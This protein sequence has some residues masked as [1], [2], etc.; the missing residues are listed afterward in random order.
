M[1]TFSVSSLYQWPRH[2]TPKAR[3]IVLNII[4]SSKTPL[5]TKDIYNLAIKPAR[6]NTPAPHAGEEIRSMRYLKTVVLRNLAAQNC[7]EKVRTQGAFT[8]WLWRPKQA[9]PASPTKR[10]VMT[11]TLP[12][13]TELTPAA[14]GVGEDWSHLNNRRQRAR[15]MK[16]ERDLQRM[17]EVQKM[18]RKAVL[19][20]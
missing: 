15:K 6:A 4:N 7:V 13:S 11:S 5:A 16:V 17:L 2:C 20:H 10:K 3:E 12:G 14:V 9:P 1:T 19:Q 18:Q 8:A